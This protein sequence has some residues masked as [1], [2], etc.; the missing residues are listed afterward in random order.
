MASDFHTA[1]FLP[2]SMPKYLL[3]NYGRADAVLYASEGARFTPG[4]PPESARQPDF[5]DFGQGL[6]ALAHDRE[7]HLVAEGHGLLFLVRSGIACGELP[8]QR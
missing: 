5:P 1:A 3:W 7:Y 6:A 4:L 8:S 2:N